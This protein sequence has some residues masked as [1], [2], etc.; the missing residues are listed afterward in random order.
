MIAGLFWL[1]SYAILS[2]WS[3]LRIDGAIPM[4]SA[5]RFFGTL[6]GAFAL[7]VIVT[8]LERTETRAFP[9][10][11][12]VIPAILPAALAVLLTSLVTY[13]VWPNHLIR[14]N[15]HL[16]WVMVW[17]GYFGTGL[18]LYLACDIYGRLRRAHLAPTDRAGA[19]ETISVPMTNQAMRTPARSGAVVPA[20]DWDWLIDAIADEMAAAPEADRHVIAARLMSK[21]GYRMADDRLMPDHNMR[22]DLVERIVGKM[23]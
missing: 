22:L 17:A 19:P 12:A 9:H 8:R 7:W 3:A 11:L 4:L 15:D 16:R 20:D 1:T 5:P 13:Q 18:G 2:L 21:A 6:V 10:P 23:R 14:F